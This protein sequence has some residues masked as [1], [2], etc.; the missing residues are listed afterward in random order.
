MFTKEALLNASV[1]SKICK[2]SSLPYTGLSE[3]G[4]LISHPNSIQDCTDG[5]IFFFMEDYCF[6][7]NVLP[8][9]FVPA[10][11]IWDGSIDDFI[12]RFH[13]DKK[14]IHTVEELV[15]Y[16]NENY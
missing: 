10:S 12:D 8:K 15:D 7:V 5:K 6:G 9:Q 13:K 11:T 14:Q 3:T 16:L 1:Y 2:R 4:R